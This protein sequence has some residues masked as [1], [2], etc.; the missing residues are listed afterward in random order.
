MTPPPIG[1]F[2][3]YMGAAGGGLLGCQGKIWSVETSVAPF[4]RVSGVKIGLGE[5]MK[6]IAPEAIVFPFFF[7]LFPPLLP[8]LP[9]NFPP[10]FGRKFFGVFSQQLPGVR[11][12]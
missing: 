10:A 7:S 9:L 12:I 1:C 5:G 2:D 6:K 3:P 4:R 8:P 11:I